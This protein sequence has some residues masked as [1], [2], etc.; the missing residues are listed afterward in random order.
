MSDIKV[1][2]HSIISRAGSKF[3]ISKQ[4]EKHLIT[5]NK[6]FV[7]VFCGGFGTTR[8]LF[9]DYTKYK[10]HL[11]D[12][13]LDVIYPLQNIDKFF[14]YLSFVNKKLSET[15]KTVLENSKSRI[16]FSKKDLI[17]I[18]NE[19]NIEEDFHNSIIARFLTAGKSSTYKH[20]YENKI[21]YI[22][23]IN[24]CKISNKS[25]K[26]IFEEYKNNPEALLFL[27]P[28]YF[29]TYNKF[30]NSFSKQED[31]TEIYVDIK[32]LLKTCHCKVFLII[33]DT[34][35]IRDYFKKFPIISINEVFQISKKKSNS[36]I[37]KNY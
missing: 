2:K 34:L 7:E 24:N 12:I 21:T 36:I 27:D 10:V 20:L 4:L 13:D 9:Y 17:K 8:R 23:F 1:L 28:P 26:D 11:N 18:L 3:L 25:H 29:G 37:I 15:F 35:L 16:K 14:Y 5:D 19:N 33:N 30:Y 22:N 32:L 31:V 6:I